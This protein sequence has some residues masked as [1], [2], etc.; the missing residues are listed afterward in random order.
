MATKIYTRTGDDGSTGLFG[1]A[2]L[3]KH[4]IR[5]EAYGTVDELNSVIGWLMTFISEHNTRELLQTIQ[6]RLFTVGSNLASDPEKEMITP[7]LTD[8]DIISI[9]VAIDTM[10]GMLPALKHFIL[11]GGSPSVSAAHLARTVCRRAE[12]RCV[13]LAY[14]SEVEPRII[15]Y[16]NRLSDYFFVLARWLG[17]NEGVEEIKWM[18]RKK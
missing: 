15:L 9:E 8:E 1:G 13:A 11:P 18:P 14:E 16:L 10:Q 12:R 2:R 7:D 6:S 4:H 5:I 3:P 17:H